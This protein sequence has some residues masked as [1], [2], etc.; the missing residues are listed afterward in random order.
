M[1][2]FCFVSSSDPNGV[3]FALNILLELGLRIEVSQDFS[4]W[5]ETREGFVFDPTH[6]LELPKWLPALEPGRHF[7]FI[8]DKT[9]YWQHSYPFNYTGV[10]QNVVLFVR[11][12]RDALYSSRRR[13]YPDL[14]FGDYL[15][16][17][18]LE[19]CLTRVK[20]LQLFY[21]GWYDLGVARV[22]RFEDLK[23]QPLAEI[24]NLVK[25]MDVD[26]SDIDIMSAVNLSTSEKAELGE[27]KFQALT[28]LQGR[29]VNFG[30]QPL[31]WKSDGMRKGIS[32]AILQTLQTECEIFKYTDYSVG[33]EIVGTSLSQDFAL[34][35][36]SNYLLMHRDLYSSEDFRIAR[37][38]KVFA[39]HKGRTVEK[40]SGLLSYTLKS[41]TI[42]SVILPMRK[43]FIGKVLALFLRPSI[44]ILVKIQDWKKLLGR[45]I[46]N[47]VLGKC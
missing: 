19:V 32:Q 12:P 7:R 40:L 30:G 36:F 15:E 9:V 47:R 33:E 39:R 35:T 26:C 22:Q 2:N 3:T 14:E 13:N 38:L 44:S 8:P 20:A 27:K 29:K 21:R 42:S 34:P 6:H 17:A 10:S 28:N 16:S 5:S 1:K 4:L 23:F 46:C 41:N 37:Y 43:R 25:M 18:D 24:R 45:Q 31:E 11:D